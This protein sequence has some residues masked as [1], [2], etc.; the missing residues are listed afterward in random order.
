M[1]PTWYNIDIKIRKEVTTMNKV[2]TNK[3]FNITVKVDDEL[4]YVVVKQDNKVIDAYTIN[5]NYED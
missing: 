4:T 1:C 2:T 5:H 3:E